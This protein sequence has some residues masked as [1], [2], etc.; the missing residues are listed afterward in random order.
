LIKNIVRHFMTITKHKWFVFR[1]CVKAGIPWRGVVH[2]LSKYSPTE[3]LE[4]VKYYQG[5]RSPIDKCREVNGYSE[6]WLHHKGRNK[7]HY[8]YWYDIKAN[9][10]AAV[11]P[12]KYV[13]EMICDNMAAGKVYKG[14]NWTPSTQLEY[15]NRAKESPFINEKIK[16]MLTCVYTDISEKG[17]DA[18]I[19]KKNLKELYEKYCK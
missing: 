15:W 8:E 14:K 4:S 11:I 13:V 17:I 2:D 18:V 7:H 19:S 10:Q 3:F 9:P 6:A 16:E 1:F 5:N 12:Y